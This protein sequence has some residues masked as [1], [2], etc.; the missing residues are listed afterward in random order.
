MVELKSGETYAGVLTGVDGFMN[1][2]LNNVICTS[3][4]GSSFFK[5]SECYI[6][7]N[8]I[9]FIRMSDENIVTAKDEMTQ[10]ESARFGT[11]G[12]GRSE[13]RNSRGKPTKWTN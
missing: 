5:M 11:R 8:N 2:A 7:G 13:S 9:K 1:L 10:R 12:R 3:K 6:R 4:D